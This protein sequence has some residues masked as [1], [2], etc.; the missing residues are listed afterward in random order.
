MTYSARAVDLWRKRTKEKLVFGFDSKCGVCG[1]NKTFEALDFHHLNPNEK[2]FNVG[3]MRANNTN[4]EKLVL[5]ISK[6]VLLCRNCHAELHSGI[7]SIPENIK[8]FDRCK[9]EALH[10]FIISDKNRY[11]RNLG[12]LAL[13]KDY[14][15][16]D[17]KDCIVCGL[18]KNNY[19][20]VCSAKCAGKR[21]RL[22]NWT[23][24]NLTEL[25]KSL[26]IPQIAKKLGVNKGSIYRRLRKL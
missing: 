11:N 15:I 6:C 19:N 8:R 20:I 13:N 24:I 18:A 23:E 22:I 25:R 10:E 12:D 1:Y 26:T 16:G 17:Y 4:W 14:N 2:E 5:E 3:R 7:L 21:A 9:A